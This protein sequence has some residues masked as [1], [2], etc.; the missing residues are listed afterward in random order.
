MIKVSVIIPA[1]NEE[2]EIEVL[3]NKLCIESIRIPDEI[4]I[5]DANSKDNTSGKIMEFKKNYPMYNVILVQLKTTAYPGRARNEGVKISKSNHIAFIDCG[6]IPE[7]NWLYELTLPFEN[8]E[9]LDI[10]WGNCSP[11]YKNSWEKAFIAVTEN[12]KR[13]RY[14]PS[15]CIKKEIFF[16]AGMF[17]ENLRASEDIVYKNNLKK[18]NLNEIF[19]DAD[20]YYTGFPN[21]LLAAFKKWSLYA[22]YS[23]YSGFYYKKI[24][25]SLFEIIIFLAVLLLKFNFLITLTILLAFYIIR[26]IFSIKKSSVR[27]KTLTE[28]VYALLLIVFIDAGRIFGLFKGIILKEKVI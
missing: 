23:V 26:T 28:F 17:P 11:I 6:V 21:S 14:V 15:S 19:V 24:I 5:V 1:F 18:F 25:L 16:K 22:E 8:D 2:K 27:L 12:I 10:V 9:A 13:N 3:L 20:S 4:V 7:S